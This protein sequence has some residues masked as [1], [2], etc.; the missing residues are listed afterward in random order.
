MLDKNLYHIGDLVTVK[1]SDEDT[2]ITGMVNRDSPGRLFLLFPD[3]SV[4]YNDFKIVNM[5]S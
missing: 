4:A 2:L 5:D 1:F 3:N